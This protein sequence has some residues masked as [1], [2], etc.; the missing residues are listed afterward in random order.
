MAKFFK[1]TYIAI[2]MKCINCY[3]LNINRSL[4]V[5]TWQ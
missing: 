4:Q 3:S 1:N 5:P 2:V